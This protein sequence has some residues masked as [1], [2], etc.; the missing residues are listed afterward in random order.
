[1]KGKCPVLE[2]N[3]CAGKAPTNIASKTSSEPPLPLPWVLPT[4][5]YSWYL[6]HIKS[7]VSNQGRCCWVTNTAS[8]QVH[9][10][11]SCPGGGGWVQ[12]T[13]H[14][15]YRAATFCSGREA[16]R[17]AEAMGDDGFHHCQ[18]FAQLRLFLTRGVR[19]WCCSGHLCLT[20]RCEKLGI[21]GSSQSS[22]SSDF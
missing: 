18:P 3:C 16:R 15:R 11:P 12:A 9:F 1:M 5:C 17:K 20:D 10:H 7:P 4:L 6:R 21:T 19:V 13:R 22:D 8:A 14:P 2:E